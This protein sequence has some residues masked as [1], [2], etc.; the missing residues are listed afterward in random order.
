[1]RTVVLGMAILASIS[2][3]SAAADWKY[4][5]SADSGDVLYV[6][7]SSIR[8]LPPVTVSRPFQVNQAWVKY[9]HSRN[10]RIK[11]RETVNQVRVNCDDNSILN[12]QTVE[13]DAS[14]NSTDSWHQDDY[15]F[16]Y[17]PAPPDTMGAAIVNFLC[18]RT[19]LPGT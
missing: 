18:G 12:A 13:Y 17:R 5:G 16:K 19:Q 15:S 2:T 8:T 10:P 4:L 14:G 7:V 1:M 11:S 9:N 3:P 6:D